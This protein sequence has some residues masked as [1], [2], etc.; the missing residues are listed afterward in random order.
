MLLPLQELGASFDS[1]SDIPAG[2][3]DDVAKYREAL[4]DAAVELD[5][6]VMEAYLEVGTI[7][8]ALEGRDGTSPCNTDLAACVLGQ[9]ELQASKVR[10]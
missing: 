7:N 2:M 9:R 8:S 4:L 5:D 1:T 6:N 3:E 10:I